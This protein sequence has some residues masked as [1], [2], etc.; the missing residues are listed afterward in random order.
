MD[1]LE[2]KIQNGRIIMCQGGLYSV[3][4]DSG[5]TLKCRARGSFRHKHMSPLPGDIAAVKYA[6]TSDGTVATYEKYEKSEK[7]ESKSQGERGDMAT[8]AVIEEI[9]ARRNALIRPPMANLDY[10]FVTMAAASPEPVLATVDKLICIAE[11]N[12]IEP[13][14]V[15]GKCEL[16]PENAKKLS[17]IYSA[18]GYKTF[19]LSCKTGEGIDE[20]SEFIKGVLPH[21]LA[22][23][24]GA[25]GVGKSTLMN[26]LFPGLVLET[27]DISRKI[28]RGRHT[29]RKVEIFGFYGGYIA[30]TPGFSMLDFE[31]FDFFG[32]EDLVGTY[33]EFREYIGECRYTKCTHT[34]EDG[35]AILGAVAEGKIPKSRHD[36]YL[37]LYGILKNKNSWDKK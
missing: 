1:K 25:S 14:V 5:E 21:K 34:K 9:I 15:I 10:M 20:I 2:Y 36:S 29:T 13:V 3:R 32:K 6:V 12:K 16:A 22:A 31:H 18:A 37:E 30:D 7:S 27:S 33:R 11:Y 4:L 8:D 26:I 35:C 28:E 17:D 19:V 23:F 24:A